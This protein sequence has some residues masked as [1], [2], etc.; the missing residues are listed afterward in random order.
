MSTRAF[1]VSFTFAGLA[2]VLAVIGS[3]RVAVFPALLCI[4]FALDGTGPRG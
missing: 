3:G 4:L 2:A 1:L